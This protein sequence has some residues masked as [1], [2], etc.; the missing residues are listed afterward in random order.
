MGYAKA[1][2]D[3]IPMFKAMIERDTG[4]GLELN[5]SMSLMVVANDF[6][7]IRGRTLAACIFDEISFWRNELT[8]NPDLEVYRAVKP[9]LGEHAGLVC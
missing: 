4:D 6:R 3:E 9:A 8:S 7:C 1:L 2:F 5:N